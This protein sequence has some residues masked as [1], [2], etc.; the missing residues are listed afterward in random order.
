[1][2]KRTLIFSLILI[3]A[4][5]NLWAQ[6]DNTVLDVNID[7]ATVVGD[8]DLTKYSLGQ[9]GLSPQPMIDAHL[10]QIQNLHPKTIRFFIQEYFNL[11][12]AHGKY[13]W[14]ILDKTLDAIVATGARPIPSICFKPAVLFQSWTRVSW[15][16]RVTKNGTNWCLSWSDIVLKKDMVSNIG[17]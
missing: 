8:I 9:G 5:F 4:T 12:P 15:Y 16:L 17:S 6:G 10:P 1:M 3:G 14:E 7:A 2:K 13:N 11:Y